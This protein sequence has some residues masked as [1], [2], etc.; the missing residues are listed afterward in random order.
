MTEIQIIKADKKY[1]KNLFNVYL[2]SISL[3]IVFWHWGIPVIREFI[4]ALPVKQRVETLETIGHVLLLLFFP[5]A[6]YLIY[7]GR[8][9]RQSSL[10]PFPGMRVIRDTKVIKGRKA[11]LRGNILIVLGIVM[12]ITALLSMTTTHLI[13]VQFKQNPFIRP[14]FQQVDYKHGEG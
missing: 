10:L 2:I 13:L 12:I 11:M 14:F 5:P 6:I 4:Q 1:R 7:I 3:L 8:K 9:I